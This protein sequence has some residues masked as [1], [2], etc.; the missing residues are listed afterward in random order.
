MGFIRN[1]IYNRR[2]D[3]IEARL[4]TD[5]SD[6]DVAVYAESFEKD[7]YAK[8]FLLYCYDY[9]KNRG[10]KE[11]NNVVNAY[12]RYLFDTYYGFLSDESVDSEPAGKAEIDE[13]DAELAATCA[14]FIYKNVTNAYFNYNETLQSTLIQYYYFTDDVKLAEKLA[15]ESTPELAENKYLKAVLLPDDKRELKCALFNDCIPQLSGNIAADAKLKYSGFLIGIGEDAREYLVSVLN[16]TTNRHY[17]ISAMRLL[18]ESG[19]SS[20]VTEY[21]SPEK[22]DGITPEELYEIVYAF[23]AENRLDKIK[24]C[25]TQYLDDE[26]F[27]RNYEFASRMEKI[28]RAQEFKDNI[29]AEIDEIASSEDYQNASGA[30]K[31]VLNDSI[32][33]RAGKIAFTGDVIV[34]HSCKAYDDIELPGKPKPEEDFSEE[35]DDE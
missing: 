25:F 28:D 19:A 5:L 22:T 13:R 35:E 23:A 29:Q 26:V 9:Y 32:R 21:F 4:N 11:A 14:N 30:F 3:S 16:T 17:R 7:D 1:L 10:L 24:H 15:E 12:V 27:A 31:A 18:N 2:A 6:K 20:V 8:A 34:F 33:Q